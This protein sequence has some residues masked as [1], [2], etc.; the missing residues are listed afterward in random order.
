MPHAISCHTLLCPVSRDLGYAYS[1]AHR[2]IIEFDILGHFCI[3]IGDAQSGFACPAPI[4]GELLLGRASSPDVERQV[5]AGNIR[6][7]FT[8]SHLYCSMCMDQTLQ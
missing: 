6:N 2:D 8:F 4:G 5:R 7:V 3:Y 1:G